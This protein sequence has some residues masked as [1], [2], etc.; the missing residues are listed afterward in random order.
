MILGN[1]PS[2]RSKDI[3]EFIKIKQKANNCYLCY[4]FDCLHA[5]EWIGLEILKTDNNVCYLT[6]SIYLDFQTTSWRRL[7][8]RN[9]IKRYFAQRFAKSYFNL[10]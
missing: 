4:W 2:Q 6:I 1:W 3:R 10:T 7:V 8:W 9:Y 5:F